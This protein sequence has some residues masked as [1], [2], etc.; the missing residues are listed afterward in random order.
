VL[1]RDDAGRPIQVQT[2]N[3]K[4]TAANAFGQPDK[5]D[6]LAGEE[7]INYSYEKGERVVKSR[8]KAK[9]MN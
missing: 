2:V 4:E 1:V 3:Y 9:G 5:L 8:V 7:I 6:Y